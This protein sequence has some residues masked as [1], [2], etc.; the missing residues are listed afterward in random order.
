MP[1]TPLKLH[2]AT[3]FSKALF[4]LDGLYF[5]K[6]LI[7]FFKLRKSDFFFEQSLALVARP[8]IALDGAAHPLG[9][10]LVGVLFTLDQNKFAVAAVFGVSFE[11]GVGGGA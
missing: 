8:R 3:C 7:G 11:D 2:L 6:P 4:Y 10:E 5:F 9:G 1:P